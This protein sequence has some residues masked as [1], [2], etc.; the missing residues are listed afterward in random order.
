M[1]AAGRAAMAAKATLTRLAGHAFYL[2]GQSVRGL[3][4]ACQL[5]EQDRADLVSGSR[6]QRVIAACHCVNLSH[7]RTHCCEC[8]VYYPIETWDGQGGHPCRNCGHGHRE[9]E[10]LA[11]RDRTEEDRDAVSERLDSV[12]WR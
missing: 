5:N 12:R 7:G 2:P 8:V 1:T 9:H 3:H 4:S 10:G 6:R 11:V